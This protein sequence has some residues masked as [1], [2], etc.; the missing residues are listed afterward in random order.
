MP[1][2]GVCPHMSESLG[3]LTGKFI[4]WLGIEFCIGKALLIFLQ[5][6]L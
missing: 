2:K 6:P 4:A 3:S 5:F 1:E